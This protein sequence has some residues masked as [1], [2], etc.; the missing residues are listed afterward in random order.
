MKLLE[1]RM[2]PGTRKDLR[3]ALLL[4]LVLTATLLH[5]RPASA[6]SAEPGKVKVAAYN[7]EWFLDVFD[8][9]YTK[10]EQHPV[11]QRKDI[12]QIAA[13][14]RKVNPDVISFEEV[15]NEHV[16][17]AMA[18]QFLMDLNYKYFCVLPTNS[19]R[20]QNVGV[21]S[22][23]PIVSA[24]SHRFQEFTLPGEDRTW[25]FARDLLRV[26]VQASETRPLDVFVVHFKSKLD[27]EGDPMGV[28]WRTAEARQV[29]KI[30]DAQL[31]T[32]PRSWMVLM[33]DFNDTP[34]GSTI[35]SLLDANDKGQAS[36]IDMHASLVGE[37]RFTYRKA[38]YRKQGP[39]DYI[40]ASPDLA[41][42]L[43]PGSAAV[44]KEEAG[45]TGGSDHLPITATFDVSSTAAPDKK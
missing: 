45:V 4:M 20:G 6:Q 11:K 37:E 31:A 23:I 34:E 41:K 7:V 8:D 3:A 19:D 14:V 13:A 35:K 27:A 16:L 1:T 29:R 42:R 28:K 25:R 36:L 33:G 40:M 17:R 32:D 18:S 43:V 12:E 2:L 22:R 39:I 5:V 9:P 10:D 38:P 15:E 26:R 30:I 44:L 24:T 21:M